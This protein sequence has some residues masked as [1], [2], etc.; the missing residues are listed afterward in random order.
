MQ[1]PH[2]TGHYFL[3]QQLEIFQTC[4]KRKGIGFL[5]PARKMAIGHLEWVA[6]ILGKA[7]ANGVELQW[8]RAGKDIR[9]SREMLMMENRHE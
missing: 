8:P 3:E 1:L 2:V 4:N 7:R 6:V 9:R 5:F